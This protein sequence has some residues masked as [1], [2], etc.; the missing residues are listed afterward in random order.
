M[1]LYS[2]PHSLSKF[3]F[4]KYVENLVF[5]AVQKNVMLLVKLIPK[6]T[7]VC[8][9]LSLLT[10]LSFAEVAQYAIHLI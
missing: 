5:G 8:M 7:V 3:V 1:F 2:A 9:I 4:R 10:L 6:F